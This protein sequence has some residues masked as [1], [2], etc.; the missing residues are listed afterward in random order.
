LAAPR[1]A[2]SKPVADVS[3]GFGL[4]PPESVVPLDDLSMPRRETEHDSSQLQTVLALVE[5][6]RGVD[7]AI[8]SE[9]VAECQVTGVEG[10]VEGHGHSWGIAQ[11]LDASDADTC[12][13]GERLV[14]GGVAQLARRPPNRR[15]LL[16][17]LG[18]DAN[19]PRVAIAKTSR[20]LD[21]TIVSFACTSP[22]SILRASLRSSRALRIG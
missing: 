5:A 21:R 15:H 19:R 7:R 9:H 17:R 2:D 16:L 8:V 22:R 3:V 20:R 13:R 12:V 10:S 1:L 14:G 18:G 11:R 4:V 6:V